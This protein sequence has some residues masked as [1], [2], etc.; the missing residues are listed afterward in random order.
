MFKNKTRLCRAISIAL[1]T[2][3]FAGVVS[4]QDAATAED[5]EKISVTGSRIQRTNLVSSSPV[6]E[7]TAAD[8]A[9]SG[10]T[11]IEDLLN[12]MPQIFAAQTSAIA[13]GATGTATVDLRNLG[14]TRT[15][16]LLNGRRL[17]SGSPQAGGI[18]ADVN[19]I[20]AALVERVE[21]LTG[22]ASATYGSDAIAG[23]VN[24]IL[25]DDFEGLE[26]DYQYSFN[27][28]D[29]DNSA[30]QQ[31]NTDAGFNAPTGS[32][33]DGKS[34]DFSVLMGINSADNKG[35]ITLYATIRDIGEVLQGNRDYS[36]CSIRN[37]P[38]VCAGSGTIAEGRVTDFS[39]YDFIVSG[40]DFLP[41]NGETYNFGA[42]SYYQ[43][44]DERKTFGAI[45]H[46]NVT[47]NLEVYAEVNFMDD[48]SV[49][50]IAPSGAFFVTSTLNCNNPLLSAQQLDA[51]CTQRGFGI[52][53]TVSAFVGKRNVEGGN[54]QDDLRHTS[55]RGVIGAKGFINDDWSFD[56]FA[57][58]GS[59]TFNQLFKNDLST[60]ALTRALNVVTDPNTGDP[61]CQSVLDG[62]DLNCVP[63]NIFTTGGVTQQALSYI[64]LPLVSKGETV[65]KQI[66]GYVAGDLTSA[67]IIMP[68]TSTGVSMVVG[69]EHRE[70]RL[71]FDPDQAFRTGDGAGQGGP[72]AAV[73]GEY[74]VD[75]LFTEVSIPILEGSSVAEQL[76]LELAYRYSDY[77]TGQTTNT[78]K[79]AADWMLNEQVRMRASFQHAVRAGNIR[80]LFRPQSLGLFNM[81]EDPCASAT[82]LYTF[83]QCARTGVTEAQYGNIAD[84]P[85]GQYNSITGGNPDLRPEESDTVSFGIILAPEFLPGFD[86][87]LD[88]FNIDVQD[89][90]SNVPERFIL[91]QCAQTG[92]AEF[93]S[94][95]NR[96]PTR[97]TLWIGNDNIVATDINI[98]FFE[99]SGVD[100]DASY[101]FNLEEFGSL[102]VN[103]VGTYLTKWDQKSTPDAPI[104]DCLGY[105]D[106]SNCG[107]PT[108][109]L[110]QNLRLSWE[111]PWDAQVTATWRY[112]GK[113]EELNDGPT[114]LSSQSYLDLTAS[115]QVFD[116]TRMRFGINNL[117]DKEP[118][119]VPNTPSGIGNGNTFPG[120]YDA[121]GRYIFAGVNFSF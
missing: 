91:D 74:D 100:F 33:T 114:T 4:A 16:T 12:D 61:V 47:D 75:E 97:G 44:P 37:V 48:R 94:L 84:N 115:W 54:R 60:T 70:E 55:F 111:T 3:P 79:Y 28:H 83:E 7:I 41:R 90:I 86:L 6:T 108:P 14:S 1:L 113:A 92:A 31:L 32:T 11:R 2:T 59:V 105:W 17:P 89:A 102:S 15:L 19:Q 8:I 39:S 76:N 82:P 107:A 34:H 24:F 49:S 85:A 22:G 96:S 25:K 5:V 109:K 65:T 64:S 26:F 121:M 52:D 40:T 88:Y 9:V 117:L 10:V 30:L 72:T 66:S 18:G 104:I 51:L 81:N 67:G 95:I 120:P 62:S 56:V 68:G 69:L 71:E 38:N 103:L 13:N 63:Y 53:D 21:I 73:F 57:N 99:T 98:G 93:C 46:Y 58:F 77:S 42:V 101:K 50:G 80:D 116:N 87:A 45:G 110:R 106:R 43:R 118:P 23:V 20:P 112:F 36:H 35:N 119:I 27:Q 78:Y 29:N